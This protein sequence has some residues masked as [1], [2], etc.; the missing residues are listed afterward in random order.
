MTSRSDWFLTSAER[1]NSATSIDR[2]HGGL[3]WTA[4]NTVTPLIHG[5]SYFARLHEVLGQTVADDIVLFTDWRGDP[6]ERLAGPGS[7]VLDVLVGL[8]RRGVRVRGLVWRSH[9]GWTRFS[10]EQNRDLAT[11]INAAGGHVLLDERI[12]R[13]GSHHQK[14]FVVLHPKAV[15]DDVA[16][17]GGI[18]LC[19]GRNDDEDHRGDPQAIDIDRRFGATPAWHDMQ[20]EIRGAAI[21]DLVETFCERWND[22]HPLTSRWTPR[23]RGT[24]DAGT[25]NI[26]P[27]A[28]APHVESSMGPHAV[29]VLRTYPAK[30]PHYPFAPNGERS[31]ARAYAKAFRRAQRLIYIEDQYLWSADIAR[32]LVALSRSNLA[33]RWSWW[34]L[35]FPTKTGWCPDRRTGSANSSLSTISARSAVADSPSTIWNEIDCRSTSTPRSASS[36]TSG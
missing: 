3:A 24:S 10:E 25:A 15:E 4:G 14:L 17:V 2:R 20:V 11:A 5:R 36:T 34:F 26:E 8:A 1:G 27:L 7:E 33:C 19:H 31:I 16:F 35:D 13:A 29:Q 22:P 32:R 18:D 6:D 12:R 30:R 21:G 9:P 23:R 28:A